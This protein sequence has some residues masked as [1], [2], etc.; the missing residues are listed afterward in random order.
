[1]KLATTLANYNVKPLQRTCI[2]ILS[3][4][5][6]TSKCISIKLN[7]KYWLYAKFTTF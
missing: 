1:M 2:Y 3:A 6:C 7:V 5:H 4:Q